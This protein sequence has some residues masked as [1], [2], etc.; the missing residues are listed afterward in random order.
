[1]CWAVSSRKSP[2]RFI[3]CEILLQ[4]TYWHYVTYE[5]NLSCKCFITFEIST[6]LEKKYVLCYLSEQSFRFIL[7]EMTSEDDTV[8]LNNP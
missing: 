5:R 7:P 1:M 2:T 6:L 4:T 3:R 8:L